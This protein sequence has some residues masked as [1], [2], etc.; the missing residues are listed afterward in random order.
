MRTTTPQTSHDRDHDNSNSSNHNCVSHHSYHLRAVVL[1]MSKYV[2]ATM[3]PMMGVT[4]TTTT[5]VR[6]IMTITLA[7]R[8]TRIAFIDKEDNN[9][10]SP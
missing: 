10:Y 7:T 1:T 5:K 6:H 8:A 2:V 9:K 3:I 4:R